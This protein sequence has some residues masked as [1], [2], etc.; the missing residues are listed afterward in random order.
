M[1]RCWQGVFQ[2]NRVW[3]ASFHSCP[4]PPLPKPLH[5]CPAMP[6][7]RL[8]LIAC[9]RDLLACLR[10]YSRLPLPALAF[11]TAPHAMPDFAQGIRM[12]PLAG[13]LIGLIGALALWL[14]AALGLPAL[15]AA[16]AALAAL[17]LATGA[18]HEDGLADFADGLG[19]GATRERKLEIMKDSRL[20]SYGAL[21]LA[22]AFAFR[23]A[24][25]AAL[26]ERF[27]FG[28]AGA[29]LVA[30]AAVS[31]TAGLLP[32]KLLPPARPDGAGRAASVPSDGALRLAGGLAMLVALLAPA[33][34]IGFGRMLAGLLL[35]A[36]GAW[37]V[38]GLARRHLG[39]L[40]GDVAGAAQQ[41]AEIAFLCGLLI[42]TRLA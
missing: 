42:G 17:A 33:C 12:L 29:A 6:D 18:M 5:L 10:F 40:T 30:A 27:G 16:I 32:L 1:F 36:G 37:A 38:T 4:L 20:G 2:H 3:P 19:G 22:A 39:G 23:A 24:A 11:E 14:A 25:L 7:F 26:A 15:P 41:I 28:A 31:R 13:V 21:A 9:A 34:G 8:T 35:A